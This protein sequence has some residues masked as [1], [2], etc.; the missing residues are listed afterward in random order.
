M[1]GDSKIWKTPPA[2]GC[3]SQGIYNRYTLGK[4]YIQG[5]LLHDPEK[6]RWVPVPAE[7]PHYGFWLSSLFKDSTGLFSCAS[8]L[9]SPDHHCKPAQYGHTAF[10]FSSHPHTWGPGLCSCPQSGLTIHFSPGQPHHGYASLLAI[11]K[12]WRMKIPI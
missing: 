6:P 2:M 3:I 1:V 10:R 4:G 11:S 12:S 9:N 8:F 7:D 5:W